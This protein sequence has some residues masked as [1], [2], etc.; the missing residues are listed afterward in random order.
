L[1]YLAAVIE[2]N[3][4]VRHILYRHHITRAD[5]NSGRKR[6]RME[7]SRGDT[8]EVIVIEAS[9]LWMC[10]GYYG[11][12]KG[13]TPDWP[14]LGDFQGKVVHPQFWPEN[15]DSEGKRVLVIASG[16]TAATLVPARSDKAAHI[17]MLQRSPTYRG[18][19]FTGIPNLVW[20]FGYFRSSWTL[21]VELIAEFVCRLP[22][23]IRETDRGQ[24]MVTLRPENEKEPLLSWIDSE[25]FNP[26]YL[27]RDIHLMPKRLNKPGWQHSQDYFREAIDFPTIDPNHAVF[28]Y[29]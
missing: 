15:L 17:T 27:M 10:Q 2:E 3:N 11:H 13:Y 26:G 12:E 8:G 4:L 9:F 5:W 25:N 18:M 23:S 22:N 6:W 19:M 28:R 24:V 7:V 20:V 14:G 29:S 1:A 16:A 21:R